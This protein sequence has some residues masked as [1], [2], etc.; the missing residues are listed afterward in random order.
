VFITFKGAETPGSRR[1]GVIG[2]LVYFLPS[3]TVGQ[4]H[5]HGRRHVARAR[6]RARA[7]AQKV[8]EKG[9]PCQGG[10][11]HSGPLDFLF[12]ESE[13]RGRTFVNNPISANL[14]DTEH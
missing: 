14:S 3:E 10:H 9:G 4:R 2:A 8:C 6:A 7:R 5:G 11:E 13:L 12:P 1:I